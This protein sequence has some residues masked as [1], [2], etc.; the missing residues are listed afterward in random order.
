MPEYSY[1]KAL[2]LDESPRERFKKQV[3]KQLFKILPNVFIVIG[4]TAV[5]TVVYPMFSYNLTNIGWEQ[6]KIISP[7]PN[8]Q[9]DIARGIAVDPNSIKLKD[10]ATPVVAYQEGEGQPE[11]VND[12]DF[13][14]ANNWFKG[15]SNRTSSLKSLPKTATYSLSIPKLNIN[16]MQVVI[17]GNDLDKNLIQYAGT[18][19]PGEYGNPVIFGHSTLPILYNPSNYLT[20]FTKIPSLKQGDEIIVNYDGIE[21]K[22]AVESY[23]EV[24]PEQ[25]EVL[26]QRYDRKT[27]TLITCVPPGTYSR[28]GVIL[29]TLED[30]N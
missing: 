24:K 29:A 6:K 11:V 26:E 4:A 25:V 9:W 17:G 20:V 15:D 12:V 16:E 18:A 19:M 22:Y 14:K 23:H 27:L 30:L 7:I 13:T 5:T 3:V 28:R 2:V 10:P 1:Y 8:D 21:Y